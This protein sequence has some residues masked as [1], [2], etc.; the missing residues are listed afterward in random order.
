[1]WYYPLWRASLGIRTILCRKRVLLCFL[2]ILAMLPA[3]AY[4]VGL[5][6]MNGLLRVNASGQYAGYII[7]YMDMLESYCPEGFEYELHSLDECMNLMENGELDCIPALERSEDRLRRFDF[8]SISMGSD[9]CQLACLESAHMN[10]SSSLDNLKVGIIARSIYGKALLE[11]ALVHSQ[12][13]QIIEYSTQ[14]E[15]AKALEDG[16]IDAVAMSRAG[17]LPGC[18][19]ILEIPTSPFYIATSKSNPAVL[20]D[21]EDAQRALFAD[22]PAIISE[23][24]RIHYNVGSNKPLVLTR[25]EEQYVAS[26]D[27]IRVAVNTNAPPYAYYSSKSVVKGLIVDLLGIISEKTGLQFTL[28][29]VR[30]F[31]EAYLL[32]KEGRADVLGLCYSDKAFCEYNGLDSTSSF[33]SSQMVRVY[34]AEKENDQLAVVSGTY[35]EFLCQQKQL[36]CQPYSTWKTVFDAILDNKTGLVYVNQNTAS[37]FLNQPR[38][39]SLTYTYQD[40]LDKA[41]LTLGMIKA[42][43]PVLLGILSKT[44]DAIPED[45][46]DRALVSSMRLDNGVFTSLVMSYPGAFIASALFVICLIIFISI[47]ISQIRKRKAKEAESQIIAA[48]DLAL[49]QRRQAELD[50][51]TMIFTRTAFETRL[52]KMLRENAFESYVAVSM[53]IGHF[54]LYS[55]VFGNEAVDSLIASVAGALNAF[56]KDLAQ[57]DRCLYGRLHDDHFIA[58]FLKEDLDLEGLSQS[59]GQVCLQNETSIELVPRFGIYPIEDSSQ[60]PEEICTIADSVLHGD[61]QRSIRYYSHDSQKKRALEQ[62]I[63][64]SFSTALKN[65]ELCMYL[66]P[67]CSR[68]GRISSAEALARWIRKSGQVIMPQVFIPVL[69]KSGLISKLDFYM[70]GQALRYIEDRRSRGLFLF[71]IS[72]NFSRVSLFSNSFE[73]NIDEILARFNVDSSLLYIEITESTIASSP[74][75]LLDVINRL[76]QKGLKIMMDDFGSGYSSLNMLMD[77]PVDFLKLDMSF[78]RS[79]VT[80]TRAQKI[81]QSVCKLAQAMRLI[82]VSEGIETEEQLFMMESFGCDFFQGFYF[83]A[84]V[85]TKA[86]EDMGFEAAASTDTGHMAAS[87]DSTSGSSMRSILSNLAVG[88]AIYPFDEPDKPMFMNFSLCDMICAAS[89]SKESALSRFVGRL[90]DEGKASITE[91]M[92]DFVKGK[93]Y[94]KETR[95]L[96]AD[97]KTLVIKA[98]VRFAASLDGAYTCYACCEDITEVVQNRQANAWQAERFKVLAEMTNMLVFDYDCRTSILSYSIV[99]GEAGMIEVKRELGDISEGALPNFPPQSMALLR[100]SFKSLMQNPGTTTIEL[101]AKLP[102]KEDVRWYAMR[103]QSIQDE[104]GSVYSLVGGFEDIQSAK[105]QE[106]E[107]KMREQDL[108]RQAYYDMTTSVL[109]RFA[110]EQ[111]SQRMLMMASP[112]QVSMLCIYDLDNLKYINDHWGH[113]RGD[114]ALMLISQAFKASP[115]MTEAVFG[116]VGGDEFGIIMPLRI[117]QEALLKGL[118]EIQSS[119]A[120]L[121]TQ[122]DEG[123]SL[124]V[125]GG[126]VI[127]NRPMAY[128][129]A[130][131]IADR[132]LYKAK[133]GGKGCFHI[134]EQQ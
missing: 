123:A 15:L 58:V 2:L 102:G 43:D 14:E 21:I 49:S 101:Q 25:E 53:K 55:D 82:T 107:S 128:A 24:S 103:I 1:M 29:E 32:A 125:S 93:L 78:V 98:K 111:A 8:S 45:M 108:I 114:L 18:K 56:C 79:V 72:V 84:P 64:S 54:S 16:Q 33:L 7:D 57:K 109:T 37:F 67:I 13:P 88:I 92:G 99:L 65:E 27:P 36:A 46:I 47:L 95:F 48:R 119:I 118:E 41:L 122:V 110:F 19:V 127:A 60:A 77:M 6:E 17:L 9:G 121:R 71:P 30:D 133:Q 90:F 75:Y 100:S 51:L 134:S 83:S 81:V 124:S 35:S 130:F 10:A 39:S 20:Y 113:Q 5:Y 106:K 86:Y 38:Y 96:R 31:E 91:R 63:L 3:R 4:K 87:E 112:S 117:S 22:N 126:I 28:I 76:H 115:I 23:L 66:Q 52:G 62:E 68:D 94:E 116:R 40:H 97:G 11:Y 104:D 129:E 74:R 85:G 132:A 61:D 70:L 120:E 34:N 44:I 59:I 69:E 80:S 26:A 12:T 42:E 131:Q 73:H 50:K 105:E 89:E